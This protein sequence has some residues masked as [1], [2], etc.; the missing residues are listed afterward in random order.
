MAVLA[1]LPVLYFPL[2]AQQSPTEEEDENSPRRGLLDDS[3]KMVYGPNTS[4]YFYEKI[5]QEQPI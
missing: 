3:T 1:V 2:M 4:L 5:C